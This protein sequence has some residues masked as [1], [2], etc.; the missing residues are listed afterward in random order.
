MKGKEPHCPGSTFQISCGQIA[1]PLFLQSHSQN[2]V[3]A[4]LLQPLFVI[5]SAGTSFP[6]FS[7]VVILCLLAQDTRTTGMGLSLFGDL[8]CLA[9]PSPPLLPGLAHSRY[10]L[11]V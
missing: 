11:S 10:L 6:S 5:G 4:L 1:E 8:V 2:L 7:Q 3:Q 9:S